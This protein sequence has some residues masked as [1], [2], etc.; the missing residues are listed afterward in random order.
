MR[1]AFVR[2]WEYTLQV[3]QRLLQL[4]LTLSLL[5]VN[6]G[7]HQLLMNLEEAFIKLGLEAT[8]IM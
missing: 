8:A 4:C 5:L 6:T 7:L 1:L 2:T 3:C